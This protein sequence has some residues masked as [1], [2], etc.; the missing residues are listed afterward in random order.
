MVSVW[1]VF[2]TVKYVADTCGTRIGLPV[3]KFAAMVMW[4]YFDKMPG[5]ICSVTTRACS[6]P[7]MVYATCQKKKC[8]GRRWQWK[9][10]H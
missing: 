1:S 9:S 6:K 7:A 3:D 5:N 4:G 10:C 2:Y 8:Y